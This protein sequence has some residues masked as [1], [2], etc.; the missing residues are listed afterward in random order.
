METVVLNIRRD[1]SLT[2]YAAPY[3]IFIDGREMTEV[4]SGEKV[5]LIIPK[6]KCILKISMVGNSIAFHEVKKEVA[7]FPEHCN[8]QLLHF[9]ENEARWNSHF[10]PAQVNR[11]SRNRHRILLKNL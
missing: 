2:G 1:K 11:R 7:L 6:Q 8:N 5:S 4:S 9:D 3:R 10:W